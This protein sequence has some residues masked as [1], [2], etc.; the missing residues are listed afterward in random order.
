MAVVAVVAMAETENSRMSATQSEWHSDNTRSYLDPILD[1]R[2]FHA[3]TRSSG[4][5]CRL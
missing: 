2:H 4:R 5:R 1:Y 3:G